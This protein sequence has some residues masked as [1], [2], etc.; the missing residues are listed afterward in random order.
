MMRVLLAVS[1]MLIVL[2]CAGIDSRVRVE[3][4]DVA[5]RPVAGASVQMQRLDDP[6]FA[7][8]PGA[9]DAQGRF[10]RELVPG[11][12]RVSAMAD[13][14]EPEETEIRVVGGVPLDV[15]IVLRAV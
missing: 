12:Y 6:S 15:R 7:W 11:R 8:G 9:V 5:G 1:A 4:V 3:V 2:A 13:G 14:F 10:E